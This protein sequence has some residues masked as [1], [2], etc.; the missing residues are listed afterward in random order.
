[1]CRSHPPATTTCPRRRRSASAADPR[2]ASVY[3]TVTVPITPRTTAPAP[4]ISAATC[5]P[6]PVTGIVI[7]TCGDRTNCTYIASAPAKGAVV[8]DA[9]TGAWAYRPTATARHDAVADH[10]TNADQHDTF[11]VTV[12]DN[13]GGATDIPVTVSLTT[14][15]TVPSYAVTAQIPVGVTPVGMAISPRGDYVYV[16]SFVDHAAVTVLRTDDATITTIPLTFRP[17]GIVVAADGRHLYVADPTGNRIA[18]I[19]TTDRST[20]FVPAG[21]KPFRM[22]LCGADLYV[23]NNQDGTVSVIDTIEAILTRTIAVGGHPYAIA[24]GG[25]R[26]YVTDYSFYGGQSTHSLSVI[27][28]A[29]GVVVDSIPVGYYPTG[30]AMSPNGRRCY[31]SNDEGSYTT[32]HPGTT[33]VIDTVTNTVVETL[34]VG[35]NSIAVG[36]GG[37]EIY[38]VSHC[39]DGQFTSTL[40]TI[41]TITGGVTGVL[42]NG[43]PDALAAHEDRIY[44]TDPWHSSVLQ[45]FARSTLV[46]DTDTANGR[47]ALTITRIDGDDDTVV[48]ETTISDPDGD[49]VTCTATQPFSGSVT[50][51]G[52]GRFRYTPNGRAAQGFVDHFAITADDGHGGVVTKTVAVPIV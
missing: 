26:V 52:G 44:L 43:M 32:S 46:V 29:G 50:D 45:V 1:M 19:D 40:S 17:E 24:A 7:G 30:I 34:P 6:D 31:V 37:V 49:D 38:V 8:I 18:V 5:A 33:T 28:T 12:S 27:D 15:M 42:I 20:V 11:I 2:G 23:A 36:E 51:L 3:I 4:P 10:A 25:G 21:N 39:R 47:P 48:F 14:M 22:A 41:D 35:G 16:T 9:G 13:D